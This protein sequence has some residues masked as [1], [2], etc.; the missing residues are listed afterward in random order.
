ME[1]EV[2]GEERENIVEEYKYWR[3]LVRKMVN[4]KKK[5][6]R[7]DMNERLENFRGKDEKMYLTRVRKNPP[8]LRRKNICVSGEPHPTVRPTNR[9]IRIS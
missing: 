5:K 9:C 6:K 8:P 4:A 2:E 3:S 7:V 1:G